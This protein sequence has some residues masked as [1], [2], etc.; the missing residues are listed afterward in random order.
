[1]R[2]ILTFHSFYLE[3]IDNFYRTFDLCGIENMTEFTNRTTFQLSGGRELLNA[4]KVEV[5]MFEPFF[6]IFNLSLISCPF[7]R[8]YFRNGLESIQHILNSVIKALMLKQLLKSL[9]SFN[10]LLQ[11]LKSLILVIL[12]LED[13]KKKP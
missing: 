10:K 11:I 3:N 2:N 9:N 1:M 12:L 4:S 6:S 5:R 7:D 13:L 8:L